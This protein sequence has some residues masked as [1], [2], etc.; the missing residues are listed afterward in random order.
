[1]SGTDVEVLFTAVRLQWLLVLKTT[2][3]NASVLLLVML[4]FLHENIPKMLL[5]IKTNAAFSIT[6]TVLI[7]VT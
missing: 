7:T 2:V 3:S 1:M 4:L 5:H 6:P